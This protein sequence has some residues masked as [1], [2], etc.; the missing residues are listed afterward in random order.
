MFAPAAQ[1]SGLRG[2]ARSEAEPWSAVCIGT[3]PQRLNQARGMKNANL[4]RWM[5]NVGI[6]LTVAMLSACGEEYLQSTINPVTDYGEVSQNLYVQVF[7]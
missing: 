5:R 2:E 6:F 1:A 7:W 4:L 3:S